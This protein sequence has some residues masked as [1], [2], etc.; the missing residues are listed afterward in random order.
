MELSAETLHFIEEHKEDDTRTL[1]LQSSKYP[2]VDMSA[3]V[4]QI[5]G[6]QIA[7]RKVPSWY[8]VPGLY[9]PLSP[10]IRYKSSYTF[11]LFKLIDRMGIMKTQ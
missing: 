5:A 10:P 4:I 11:H 9:Y 7:A 8:K 3:A 1:A 2:K 6:R